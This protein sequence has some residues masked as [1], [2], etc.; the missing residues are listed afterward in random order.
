MTLS[1]SVPRREAE[2]AASASVA[3]SLWQRMRGLLARPPLVEG[4]ALILPQ[5][6]Q[7]H[8]VG[9]RYPIDVVFCDREW[10]VIRLYRSMRPGRVT[11]W[12]GRARWALELP[13]GGAA[14]IEVGDRLHVLAKAPR[15]AR[16]QSRGVPEIGRPS[17][18]R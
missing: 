9:M 1:I 14:D 11:R 17:R 2:F 3:T 16:G 10:N 15:P 5:A 8:T 6:H 4:Q 18:N 13:L 12:I 7:I